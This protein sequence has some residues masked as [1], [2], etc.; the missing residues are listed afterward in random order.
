MVLPASLAYERDYNG[1]MRTIFSTVATLAWALWFGGL[2]TMFVVTRATFAHSHELGRTANPIMFRTFEPYILIVAAVA[3]ISTV[4][5]LV[6]GRTRLLKVLF[7]L[8]VLSGAAS[9][10]AH[11]RVSLPLQQLSP[12]TPEWKSLHGR[13]MMLYAAQAALLAVTGLLI[14]SAIA[15]QN[16]PLPDRHGD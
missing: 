11:F 4:L 9:A 16:N 14:P 6:S 2:I 8:L 10:Y 3:V 7:A 15:R 5:W 1:S 13:S 12:S